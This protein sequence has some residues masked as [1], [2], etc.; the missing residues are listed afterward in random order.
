M[1]GIIIGFE[2][3][4][5]V[6]KKTNQPVKGATIYMNCKSS[7][8]FGYVGKKEYFPESSPIYNRVIRPNLEKFCDESSNIFGAEIIIDYDVTQRGNQT[9]TNVVDMS[10]TFPESKA[11][12]KGA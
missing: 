12:K 6:S 7:D 3:V 11:D 9:F 5:Y 4:D 8:A 2:P 10:I 1:K